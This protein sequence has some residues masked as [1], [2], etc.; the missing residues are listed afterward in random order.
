VDVRGV[1]KIEGKT[2][3]PKNEEGTGVNGMRKMEDGIRRVN[4]V[5]K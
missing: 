3:P 4:V 1:G 5:L 2:T